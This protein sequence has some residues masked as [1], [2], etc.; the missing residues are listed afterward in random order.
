VRRQ[1][2]Q[3]SVSKALKSL[4]KLEGRW[5]VLGLSR[6]L[7]VERGRIYKLIYKGTLTTERHPQTGCHLIEDDPELITDLRTRWAAKPRNVSGNTIT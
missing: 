2:G 7:G 4:E 6:E 3:G 5:T 1:N